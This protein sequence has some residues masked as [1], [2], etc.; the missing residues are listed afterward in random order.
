[1]PFDKKLSRSERSLLMAKIRSSNTSPERVL[2]GGLHAHGIM[3]RHIYG[4]EKIDIALPEYKLAIFVDGCFWHQCPKHSHIPKSN[5]KYWLPKLE[6]NVRRAK[7]KDARLRRH[8][9]S[10]MHIWEH[11]LKTQEDVNRQVLKIIRKIQK[12]HK[13]DSF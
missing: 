4:K 10:V 2:I 11:S 12:A 8:G 9:W 1:M 6:G 5:R 7:A 3:V 13:R